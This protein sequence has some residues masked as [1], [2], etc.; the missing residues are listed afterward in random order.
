MIERINIDEE[1][2]SLNHEQQS[3]RAR[4]TLTFG[5]TTRYTETGKIVDLKYD[6]MGKLKQIIIEQQKDKLTSLVA[7]STTPVHL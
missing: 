7:S 3:P 1:V 5:A 6:K 4:I 2:E